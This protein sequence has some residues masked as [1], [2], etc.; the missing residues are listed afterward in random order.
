MDWI[1]R[2]PGLATLEHP[3]KT[4]LLE[5]SSLVAIPKDTNLFGPG[6]QPE[7]LMLLV[8]GSVRV[9]QMSES[10]REII[11]YRINSGESCIM[12]TA[13]L[14]AFEDY[15]ARGIAECDLQAVAVSREATDQL[16]AD[17][18]QFRQFIFG[19]FAKRITDLFD[20]VE[21]VAFQRMD[22]R[23]AQKLIELAEGEGAVVYT[24]HQKIAVEL[25]TAREV[26]SRQLR[27]FQR[28]GWIQQ[29]RGEITLLNI[30]NM[31]QLASS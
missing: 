9:E 3:H 22:V 20:V 25:G 8:A 7:S 1:E 6:T 27:E 5:Q 10:G 31:N 28:R 18:K 24:T 19:A 17:S 29:S 21:E 2:F 4:L 30:E 11:L 16:L 15:S 23:L 13:C 26:V 12:T 14:L